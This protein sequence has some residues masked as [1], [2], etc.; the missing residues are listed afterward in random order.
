MIRTEMIHT[1]FSVDQC[2]SLNAYQR[3]GIG[4]P[5]TCPGKHGDEQVLLVAL[6]EGWRCPMRS[7]PHRQRWAWQWMSDWSWQEETQ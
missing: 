1:P 3:S 6:Q 4:H 7:C 5:F 2:M